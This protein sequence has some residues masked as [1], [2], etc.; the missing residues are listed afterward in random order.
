M[1][2]TLGGLSGYSPKAALGTPIWI[3]LTMAPCSVCTSHQRRGHLIRKASWYSLGSILSGFATSSGRRE[4]PARGQ[5]RNNQLRGVRGSLWE[6]IISIMGQAA[7]AAAVQSIRT[8]RPANDQNA[9]ELVTTL[10]GA[11]ANLEQTALSATMTKRENK[12][13]IMSNISLKSCFSL[14]EAA[15]IIDDGCIDRD[16]PEQ[17]Y[18]HTYHSYHFEH[19]KPP[20][21]RGTLRAVARARQYCS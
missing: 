4:T 18:S 16:P 17:Q 8:G 6:R 5:K 10:R 1:T 7:G 9:A 21:L 12:G 15:A 13:I 2:V 11:G 3:V 20:G 14:N 19:V